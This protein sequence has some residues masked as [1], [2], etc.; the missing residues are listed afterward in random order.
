MLDQ[1]DPALVAQVRSGGPLGAGLPD[2]GTNR[3]RMVRKTYISLLILP[4]T[5]LYFASKLEILS[6]L[7][8]INILA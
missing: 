6:V 5:L 4:V 3:V 7:R 2:I 8:T 1:E